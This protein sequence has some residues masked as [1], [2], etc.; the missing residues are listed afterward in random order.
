MRRNPPAEFQL[1]C[2]SVG[3]ARALDPPY[4][5]SRQNEK[6]RRGFPPGRTSSVSISRIV[7]FAHL[8][9]AELGE[10]FHGSEVR[11]TGGLGDL[12]HGFSLQIE[13]VGRIVDG[14]KPTLRLRMLPTKKPGAVSRP[15]TLCEFQFAE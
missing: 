3:F 11:L 14:A 12:P 13:F 7:R 9:Q 8:S 4:A 15:G 10:Y 1:R 6:A 5:C 2:R